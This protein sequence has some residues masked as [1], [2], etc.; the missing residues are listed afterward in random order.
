MQGLLACAQFSCT[1]GSDREVLEKLK[2]MMH[3]MQLR[4]PSELVAET[5]TD[6]PAE[7]SM[8]HSRMCL[9]VICAVVRRKTPMVS[10]MRE[11]GVRRVLVN[12]RT[13]RIT[14]NVRLETVWRNLKKVSTLPHQK[15][16]VRDSER[17][18]EARTA[19]LQLIRTFQIRDPVLDFCHDLARTPSKLNVVLINSTVDR[20]NK[21][22]RSCIA[23]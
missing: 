5:Y 2:S 9:C 20:Q 4:L 10:A 1:I 7:G 12:R 3:C 13:K 8:A 11:S 16:G 19:M 6:R 17:T 23:G 15:K 21:K 18:V 14:A 22:T